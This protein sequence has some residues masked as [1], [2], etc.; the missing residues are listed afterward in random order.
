M[1]CVFERLKC[2]FGGGQVSGLQSLANRGE[3]LLPL[4]D[5]E[6]IPAGKRPLMAKRDDVAEGGFGGRQVAGL[7][8]LP[9]LL[10]IVLPGLKIL[11]Q[12]LTDR[13]AGNGC[14]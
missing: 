13:N 3:I 14:C 8:C 9:K 11:L 5:L 6:S 10:K 7:K 1:K 4:A 2:I 12:L